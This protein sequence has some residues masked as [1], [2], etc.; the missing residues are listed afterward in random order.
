MHQRR[1]RVVADAVEDFACGTATRLLQLLAAAGGF[2]HAL[3][4]QFGATLVDVLELLQVG[5]RR[6]KMPMSSS[7]SCSS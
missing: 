5:G 1:Q 6:S 2:G 7:K 3:F 4:G